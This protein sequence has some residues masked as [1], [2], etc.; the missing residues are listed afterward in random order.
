LTESSGVVDLEASIMTKLKLFFPGKEIDIPRCYQQ[1]KKV[2]ADI[3]KFSPEEKNFMKERAS[4]PCTS[5][6]D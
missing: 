6:N 5:E 2:P 4:R 3:R 1:I